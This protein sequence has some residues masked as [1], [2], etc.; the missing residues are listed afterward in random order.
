MK[1]AVA[2]QKIIEFKKK[3]FWSSQVDTKALNEKIAGLNQDGWIVKSV[4]PNASLMGNV[5]SYTLL[6]EL[7]V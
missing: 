3:N 7:K 5:F 1:K 6:V 2:L 4:T